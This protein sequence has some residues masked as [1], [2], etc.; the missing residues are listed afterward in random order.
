MGALPLPCLDTQGLPARR[1]FRGER[2][3]DRRGG[4]RGRRQQRPRLGGES[5]CV[6]PTGSWPAVG[7]VYRLLASLCVQRQLGDESCTLVLVPVTYRLPPGIRSVARSPSGKCPQ[8]TPGSQSWVLSFSCD[9][10]ELDQMLHTC[11][12]LCLCIPCAQA[13]R[14]SNAL[15]V[16]PTPLPPQV[17]DF[18]LAKHLPDPSKPSISS[19]Y[20]VITHCAPEVL[21]SHAQTQVGAASL[22]SSGSS[23]SARARTRGPLMATP[24]G[25][26]TYLRCPAEEKG[27]GSCQIVRPYVLLHSD[28]RA[29]VG[30]M[31]P[32]LGCSPG[33][34]AASYLS[35]GQPASAPAAVR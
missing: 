14:A 33:S 26:T 27:Y 32:R 5:E 18:G 28:I 10:G 11:T 17:S 35:C 8:L 21:K 2:A 15:R 25:L 3:A 4:Q 30:P 7:V 20:G 24:P 34:V 12:I 29:P 6:P 13:L 16:D 22:Y 1:P 19:S 31:Y 9:N 23:R